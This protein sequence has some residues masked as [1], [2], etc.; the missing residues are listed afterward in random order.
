MPLQFGSTPVETKLLTTAD[1]DQ[2]F[3]RRNEKWLAADLRY[4]GECA[5]R[6]YDIR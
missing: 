4:Y 2:V 6:F 1:P 5:E 3:Y